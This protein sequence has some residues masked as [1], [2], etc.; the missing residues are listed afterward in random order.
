M[1][2]TW[3]SWKV[4]FLCDADADAGAKDV[5]EGK[6][7]AMLAALFLHTPFWLIGTVFRISWYDGIM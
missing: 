5:V 3:I 6:D 2:W 1:N 4:L 7:F